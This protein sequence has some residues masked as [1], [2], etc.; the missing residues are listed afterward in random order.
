MKRAREGPQQSGFAQARN[1]LQEHVAGSQQAHQD[2]FDYVILTYDDF[3]DF[4]PDCIEPLNGLLK[5]RFGCHDIIVEQAA[6]EYCLFRVRIARGM[7]GLWER[8]VR[9]RPYEN[10]ASA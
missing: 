4:A 10:Y 6:I 8:P 9:L 2:A 3:G 7:R 1:A 5:C